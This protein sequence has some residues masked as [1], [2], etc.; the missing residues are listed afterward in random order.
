MAEGWIPSDFHKILNPWVFP[1]HEKYNITAYELELSLGLK[2]GLLQ[3][4]S[5]DP[6]E[7]EKYHQLLKFIDSI[8]ITIHNQMGNNAN[9]NI[10]RSLWRIC[11]RLPTVRHDH[12]AKAIIREREEIS[13]FTK[14]IEL[15]KAICKAYNKGLRNGRIAVDEKGNLYIQ[16]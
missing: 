15:T 8:W 9:R 16:D 6:N 5:I 2:K 13:R 1:F 4:E 7:Y 14:N 11:N 10:F 12:L 3:K